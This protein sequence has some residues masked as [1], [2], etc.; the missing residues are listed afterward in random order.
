MAT[1]LVCL[2]ASLSQHLPG[3]PWP[4]SL[5]G[6]ML[7][8][9]AH[10][11]HVDERLE[12]RRIYLLSPED[13]RPG[14]ATTLIFIGDRHVLI[15]ISEHGRAACQPDVGGNAPRTARRSG[16]RCRACHRLL[17]RRN[18]AGTTPWSNGTFRLRQR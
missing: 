10:K 6:K 15:R 5:D 18:T 1:Y 8:H 17:G 3:L 9:L 16:T 11:L 12:P 2:P 7:P 4:S 14:G 13:F